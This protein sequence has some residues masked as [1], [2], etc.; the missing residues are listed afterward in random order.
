[1]AH[2]TL[3]A[4]R[5]VVYST[6]R[7]ERDSRIRIHGLTI[8]YQLTRPS[9]EKSRQSHASTPSPNRSTPLPT[10]PPTKPRPISFQSAFRYAPCPPPPPH[11]PSL[12]TAH[13]FLTPLLFA[14][15]PLRYPLTCTPWRGT[16]LTCLHASRVA[17]SRQCPLHQHDAAPIVHPTLAIHPRPRRHRVGSHGGCQVLHLAPLSRHRPLR[18]RAMPLF[19]IPPLF[20]RVLLP[21]RMVVFVCGTVI[22]SI[23]VAI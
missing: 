19:R 5:R 11:A 4:H 3:I 6:V 10:S 7:P 14:K 21:C 2:T 16:L 23:A 22:V 8:G 17:S 9:R 13:S 15:T 12:S 18:Q 1:M 20:C